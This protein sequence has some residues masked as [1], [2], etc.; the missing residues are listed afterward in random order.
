M[1]QLRRRR[2]VGR[3]A[4]VVAVRFTELLEVQEGRTRAHEGL[5]RLLLAEAVDR[6]AVVAQAHHQRGEVGVGRDDGEAIEVARVQQVHGV[7]HHRHV[8]RVL[9]AGVGELLDR[10]DRPGV[11]A[12]LPAHQVLAFPVAIGAAHVGDAVPRDFGEDHLDLRRRGV[13]GVDQQGDA[14]LGVGHAAGSFRAPRRR[15]ARTIAQR[16]DTLC[17]A[18]RPPAARTQTSTSAFQYPAARSA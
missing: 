14:L 16:S 13:V 12:L 2:R 6:H 17:A 11:Q 15:D 10:P 8:G 18:G 3:C 5:R 7:D 4:V 1:L 9:A